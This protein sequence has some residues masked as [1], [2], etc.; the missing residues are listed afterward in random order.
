VIIR[1]WFEWWIF[2][3]VTIF[4]ALVGVLFNWM[5]RKTNTILASL[6]THILADIAIILIGL[7]LF[8]FY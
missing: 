7:H 3:L 5:Y 1:N 2:I 8:G 6:I 4:L